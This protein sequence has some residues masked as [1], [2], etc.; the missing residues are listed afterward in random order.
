MRSIIKRT[1]DTQGL[2]ETFFCRRIG[3]SIGDTK[4]KGNR[5]SDVRRVAKMP[6]SH[7]AKEAELSTLRHERRQHAK[8]KQNLAWG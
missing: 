8:K 1:K 4:K 3:S 6:E 2:S 7:E 5:G